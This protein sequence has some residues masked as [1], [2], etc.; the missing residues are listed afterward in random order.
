M[1]KNERL[2][3][4]NIEGVYAE[5]KTRDSNFVMKGHHCH[6][7]YELFYVEAGACRFLSL[8]RSAAEWAQEIDAYLRSGKRLTADPDK[9]AA[10][11]IR[12][13]VKKL[14]SLYSE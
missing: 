11:D 2:P 9:M 1:E 4:R 5:T 13:Y 8:D 12:G 10:F 7:C 3:A 6:T 14:E